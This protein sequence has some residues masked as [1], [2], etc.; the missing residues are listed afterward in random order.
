[1]LVGVQPVPNDLRVR[2]RHLHARAIARPMVWE[3]LRLY[4]SPRRARRSRLVR[5]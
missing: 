3:G 2:T 4:W 5:D 1:V